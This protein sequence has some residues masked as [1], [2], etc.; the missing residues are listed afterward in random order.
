MASVYVIDLQRAKPPA[1]IG[2]KARNIRFLID[3]QCVVP[4][5]WVCTWEAFECYRDNDERIIEALKT[6][7]AALLDP[8]RAYAVRSSGNIEDDFQHSFAGQ[9]KSVLNVTSFEGLK[10][11]LKDVTASAY[12]PRSI[13]Y[14][15]NTPREFDKGPDQSRTMYFHYV[16]DLD[17]D[18]KIV[19][20]RYYGDS[21][22]I[23]MLW[24]PLKPVEGGEKGNERGNPHVSVKEVLALWRAS[25]S[26][27]T[28]N[29]WLN[30]DPTEEDRLLPAEE[31]KP[32]EATAQTEPTTPA[33]EGASPAAETAAAADSAPA[34]ET[35][36]AEATTEAPGEGAAPATPAAETEPAPEAPAPTPEPAPESPTPESPAPEL[37]AAAPETPE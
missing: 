27:E 9:F 29:K 23:D 6:E 32:A 5:T 36:A 17:A 26:E 16:L 1:S 25:V 24:T 4:R 2:N 34:A 10:A 14:R 18:G 37:P 12:S 31:P 22:R 7:L 30:V 19:G 3:K 33:A 11:A 21:A 20:G 28:R 35:T 13:T 15:L 8:Q